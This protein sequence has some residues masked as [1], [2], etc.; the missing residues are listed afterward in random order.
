MN[1]K[2]RVISFMLAGCIVVSML[3]IAFAAEEDMPNE[4]QQDVTTAETTVTTLQDERAEIISKETGDTGVYSPY[5]TINYSYSSSVTCGTIRYISQVTSGSHFYSA[6]WPASSFGSYGSPSSE[7][8]TA[9]CSMALS[10]VGINKTP[11]QILEAHNGVTYFSG[12]GETSYLTPSVSTAMSN[13]INGNG[14]YSPPIIHLNNY[15]SGGHYL[16]LIGQSGTTYQTLD[17]WENSVTRMTISGTTATYTKSGA[18]KTDT[19]SSAIQYYNANASKPSTSVPSN[20]S[21]TANKSSYVAGD[22]ITLTPTAT[23]AT[24]YAVSV[25]RDS[26][27]NGTCLYRNTFTGSVSYTP[28]TPGVYNFRFDAGNSAGYISIDKKVIVLAKGATAPN[29]VYRIQPTSDYELTATFDAD[30]G[31]V[32]LKDQLFASSEAYKITYDENGYYSII[33]IA[34]GKA[35]DVVNAG[36]A[37]GTNVQMWVDYPSSAQ[38]WQFIPYGNTYLIIPQ[39]ATSC[40][41]DISSG[42]ISAGTNIQIWNANFTDAQRWRLTAYNNESVQNPIKDG[43]YHIVSALSDTKGLDVSGGSADNGTN[44]QIYSNTSDPNQIF[45]VNYIGNGYYK[46]IFKKSGKSVDVTGYGFYNGTNVEEYEYKNTVNQQWIIKDA[47]DGYYYVVSRC[48][49]LYL[50]VAD[51][52][53]DNGTN[54]QVWTGNSTAAQKWKF[55]PVSTKEK[56]TFDMQ[57]GTIDGAFA[58]YTADG[59]NVGRAN[60]YL[61]IYNIGNTTINTNIYGREAAVNADGLITGIRAWGD[62]NQLTVPSDGF[63][64]SGHGKWDEETSSH[65][66]GVQFT[67]QLNTG[68]YVAYD[69]NTKLVSAYKNQNSYLAEQ[70]YV[71]SNSTYGTLPIPIREG[72]TFDGW[73]TKAEGG[74]KITANSTY[75]T[76][77]LYAHWKSNHTHTYT[78]TYTWSSDHL[79]CKATFACACGEGTTT[80]VTCKVTS[81]VG[82]G[83][84]T[85]TATCTF[86]GQT[87]QDVQTVETSSKFTDVVK[88]AYYYNAVEWAVANKVTSGTTA[89]TFSP[90]STCTRAQVVAFLWNLN[91]KPEPK[92]TNNPFTDMKSTDWCYKAVMWAVENKI[93][94]GTTATTFSPNAKCNRAQI[95]AFLWNMNGKPTVTATNNFTD[96]KSTD[97]CYKAIMWAVQN[98]ITSGTSATTFSPNQVCT[99]AQVVTFL[100]NMEGKPTT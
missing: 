24:S 20:L 60:G 55:Q 44:I 42:K 87:Y 46:L 79:S 84:A 14:K 8:G 65:I 49:G 10:Y 18:T 59:I 25:W 33:N 75:S 45:T 69:S 92:A 51:G 15:S 32:L 30:S 29:G 12:W 86:N 6:Y 54:V 9:S 63:I 50:D 53:T 72:Y 1:W 93:T 81:T 97:W 62:A 5:P 2:K 19:V 76:D 16:L 91:G 57:G 7:C 71:Y 78:P 48:N 83:I 56:I 68:N 100:W 80:K 17:P 22:T 77:K 82:S 38:R 13:Y 37:N 36:T 28:T 88:T 52:K 70:K 99:R 67:N 96:V 41:L 27:G 95:V 89:T 85:F 74:T 34:N 43:D 90:N 23:G 39:C 58:T 40:C 64:V 26:W 4:P 61:V 31:N 98:K 47:G 35:L 3:P 21:V 73:Y 94:S 66:G 11:K